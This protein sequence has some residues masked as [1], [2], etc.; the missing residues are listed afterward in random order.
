MSGYLNPDFASISENPRS[1][2]L[3]LLRQ[4]GLE[5]VAPVDPISLC[6]IND[7]PLEYQ[8][9]QQ[10]GVLAT[11]LSG[12]GRIEIVLN[13][14]DSDNKSG[15]S[16][17]TTLRRRQRFSLS[18][19]IAHAWFNS[20]NNDKLQKRL[21]DPENPH[22][23]RYVRLRERQANEFASELL[24]PHNLLKTRLRTFD[25]KDFWNSTNS[26]CD[27]FDVSVSATVLHLAKLAP[28]SSIALIFA[29]NGQSN[30]VPS[31]SPDF[32]E[33]KFFFNS[34]GAIPQGS[35]AHRLFNDDKA[36]LSCQRHRSARIWFPSKKNADKYT[37]DEW[38]LRIG[39]KGFLVFLA[40]D[41]DPD[42]N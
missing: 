1:A 12:K 24:L 36:K 38:V 14:R 37:I 41:E 23:F 31:W 15:L 10:P 22:S 9:L 2:A 5:D 29:E 35:L 6:E 34:S 33:A 19:E 20:H 16:A 30:Q 17:D 8:E 40:I 26:L 32:E 7:W 4:S 28:F 3:S 27:E 25:W 21:T 11:T 39:N 13:V 42:W 18:H